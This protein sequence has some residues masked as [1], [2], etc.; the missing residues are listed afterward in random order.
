[1]SGNP[2]HPE[3]ESWNIAASG[4]K[5]ETVPNVSQEEDP[6]ADWPVDECLPQ[7]PAIEVQSP[8]MV[9]IPYFPSLPTP[10]VQPANFEDP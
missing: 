3:I 6:L 9:S 5:S 10:I 4:E 2:T 1:M 7:I 8:F